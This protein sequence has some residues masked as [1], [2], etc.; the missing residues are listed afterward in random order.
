MADS[1]RDPS[2]IS[3]DE[4]E[5]VMLDRPPGSINGLQYVYG[6][7]YI[8][9]SDNEENDTPAELLPF[10]SPDYDKLDQI[11][12]EPDS[13]VFVE[14][15]INEA[16]EELTYSGIS[17]KTYGPEFA[18]RVAYSHY[19]AGNAH[20]HSITHLSGGGNTPLSVGEYAANTVSRWPHEDGVAELADDHPDGWLIDA[21]ATIGSQDDTVEKIESAVADN[22]SGDARRM[23]SVRFNPADSLDDEWAYPIDYPVL[24]EGLKARQ[25]DKWATKNESDAVAADGTG[26]VTG[27][28]T[29][30]YG[31]V[32]DP[33]NLY[34]NKKRAWMPRFDE[35]TSV[36]THPL[37]PTSIPAISR[38]ET[39]F[40]ACEQAAL[41]GKLFWLPYFTGEQTP[42]KYRALYR[43]LWELAETDGLDSKRVLYGVQ[44]QAAEATP[45]DLL[46]DLQFWVLHLTSGSFPKRIRALLDTQTT[47]LSQMALADESARVATEIQTNTYF[48]PPT[49]DE[50]N[51]TTGPDNGDG[52]DDDADDDDKLKQRFWDPNV[53]HLLITTNPRYFLYTTR[54]P[55]LSN[56]NG[57]PIVE[58]PGYEFYEQLLTGDSISLAKLLAAYR[59]ALEQGYD[60]TSDNPV[61]TWTILQQYAQLRTIAGAGQLD[62]DVPVN[63]E[64]HTQF[65][66]ATGTNKLDALHGED[67]ARDSSQT[68][69]QLT[70]LM[71][72]TDTDTDPR[73]DSDPNPETSATGGTSDSDGSAESSDTS[74]A[75]SNAKAAA[76]A[77]ESF[78]S[79][80][81]LL[82]ENP[83]RRAAFTLG[84]LIT[85]VANHQRS[86][87][88][89]P[90]TKQYGPA[91]I[92]KRNFKEH[93]TEV[94]DLINTHAAEDYKV[95]RYET[96]VTQLADDLSHADPTEWSLSKGDIQFHVGLGMAFGAKYRGADTGE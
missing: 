31:T 95:L 70:R 33:Q 45:D 26:Y 16:N 4:F 76:Q 23:V 71:T 58:T 13:L 78:I 79:S 1:F 39:L 68:E 14:F 27:T 85:T 52:E 40:A 67:R 73:S 84:A 47:A 7:L 49:P 81:E 2:T 24:I 88:R 34:T 36:Y 56:D 37:S 92:T 30:V 80:H 29:E 60:P 82:R 41:D 19:D 77:Y 20:D 5:A 94:I 90:I 21:L 9:G 74:Q 51:D 50:K 83:E 59:S 62:I 93:T 12:N 86:K 15:D 46:A 53:D 43:I 6:Q 3:D 69:P 55:D 44:K 38:S 42:R 54:F 87:G 57:V 89:A 35:D 96:Q 72:D 10:L 22:L 25:R 64:S 91:A 61:P 17:I 75:Q 11:R 48:S 66:G 32:T 28:N 65:C 8:L 18:S 63:A